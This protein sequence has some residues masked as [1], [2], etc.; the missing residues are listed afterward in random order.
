M[1]V[2]RG[3]RIVDDDSCGGVFIFHAKCCRNGL[4]SK[5]EVCSRESGIANAPLV[6]CL[7]GFYLFTF[8]NL[9]NNNVVAN[10][11]FIQSHIIDQFPQQS[12]CFQQSK[13]SFLSGTVHFGMPLL[14][15]I[16]L[17]RIAFVMAI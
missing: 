4:A 14:S 2:G 12:R 10:Y 5:R 13:S 8:C 15:T 16:L 1:V 6:S 9:Y 7:I 11:I 3:A 17:P